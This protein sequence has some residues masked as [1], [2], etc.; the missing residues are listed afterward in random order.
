MDFQDDLVEISVFDGTNVATNTYFAPMGIIGSY[1]GK[2]RHIS[3]TG[4]LIDGVAETTT[5]TIEGTND[6]DVANANWA[7]IYGYDAIN[8]V[9]VNQV[10][11]TNATVIY[12][13]RFDNWNFRFIRAR[14]QATAPTNTVIIKARGR[15]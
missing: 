2:F 8:N 11:A 1:V 6:E 15:T 9:W 10:A 5:L 3:L 13:L 4:V 14:I 12:A 7:Q